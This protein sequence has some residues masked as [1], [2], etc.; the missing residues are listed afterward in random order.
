MTAIG[1]ATVGRIGTAWNVDPLDDSA[2]TPLW[3][4]NS[5]NYWGTLT[6]NRDATPNWSLPLIHL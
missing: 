5:A 4:T 2:C 6:S 1:Y 3:T